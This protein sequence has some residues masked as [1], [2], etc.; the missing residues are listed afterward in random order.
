MSDWIG[1]I[2]AAI[3]S[4]RIPKTALS[5]ALMLVAGSMMLARLV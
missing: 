1:I 2:N 5:M 3:A 4:P